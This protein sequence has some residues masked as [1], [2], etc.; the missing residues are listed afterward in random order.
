MVNG[1]GACDS[2][3]TQPKRRMDPLGF[4]M[5]G[6]IG[7]TRQTCCQKPGCMNL[8]GCLQWIC[9]RR[10]PTSKSR[11]GGKSSAV[12]ACSPMVATIPAPCGGGG[13]QIGRGCFQ[14]RQYDLGAWDLLK[15]LCLKPEPQRPEAL[16]LP[17]K[18]KRHGR[19]GYWTSGAGNS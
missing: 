5:S 3:A 2:L 10:A 17:Q 9:R 18:L 13:R 12:I 16:W 8:S 4:T 15:R 11:S 7:G 19:V 1:I 14:Q 6:P